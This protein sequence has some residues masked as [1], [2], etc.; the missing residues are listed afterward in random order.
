VATSHP[1][2]WVEISSAA[3]AANISALKK[4]LGPDTQLCAVVKANAYGHDIETIARLAST[5]GVSC[6]AVDHLDEALV[7]RSRLSDAEIIIL[8][9]APPE[10]ADTIVEN[11]FI[12]T[13]YSEESLKN[14][15]DAALRARSQARINL[16]IET[17]THRQGIE[18]KKLWGFLRTIRQYEKTIEFTGVSSHFAD[19]ETPG[20]A[21]S[22]YQMELFAEALRLIEEAGLAPR[23]KHFACSAAIVLDPNTHF[24]LV[25]SGIA[26]Y[27]IWPSEAVRRVNRVRQNAID[28]HPVLAWK[29]RIAQIKELQPG[30]CVGYGMTFR[31]DRPLRIAVLPV[32][33]SDGYR[34]VFSRKASVLV[35]GHA[36]PVI[37]TICMNMMMIDVSQLPMVKEG[38]IVTLLGRDGMH[39][40]SAEELAEW[41]STIAY[42]IVTQINPL[43]PRLVV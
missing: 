28:L 1:K 36:C 9:Y 27:G 11:R 4:M 13:I 16:K 33:Y 31:S 41:G 37:G 19:A 42:E 35:R 32:G 17:G 24:N 30:E 5:S 25:R 10:W 14:L 39:Q 6:F 21:Y 40:I 15:S 12:Q 2:T 26:L 8:G 18:L 20:S 3:L 38:D 7:V 29:T 22:A 34:R 43:L 23:Y